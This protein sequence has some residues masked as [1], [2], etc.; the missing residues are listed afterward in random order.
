MKTNLFGAAVAVA[1]GG[2]LLCSS[3]FAAASQVPEPFQ[4]SDENSNYAIG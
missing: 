1:L 2:L 3:S 4:G